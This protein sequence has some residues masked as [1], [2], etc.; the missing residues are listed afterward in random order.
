MIP[1][2]SVQDIVTRKY[3][4]AKYSGAEAPKPRD[5][6]RLIKHSLTILQASELFALNKG[7]TEH[8]GAFSNIFGT[9]SPK[10]FLELNIHLKIVALC[11]FVETFMKIHEKL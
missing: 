8:S 9:P 2:A 11:F 4:L 7:G 6:S 1:G 10:V 3:F 5:E